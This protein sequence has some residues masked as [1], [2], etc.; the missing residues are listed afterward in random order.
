VFEE[1]MGV[2]EIIKVM[3]LLTSSLVPYVDR[4]GRYVAMVDLAKIFRD[5][6]MIDRY[7]II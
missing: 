1:G 3:G 6:A 7:K 2:D 4:D 5:I